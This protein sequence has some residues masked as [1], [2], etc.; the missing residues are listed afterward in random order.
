MASFDYG[1]SPQY[2]STIVADQSPVNGNFPNGVSAALRGLKPGTLYHFRA[3]G[4]NVAGVAKGAD[5]TFT[6][7]VNETAL[8]ALALGGATFTPA[9]NSATLS[10]TAVVPPSK[11]SI[12]VTP[13]AR[14]AKA[15][16]RVNGSVV[17]AGVASAPLT[18]VAGDNSIP[19]VVTAQD[20]VT[21]RTYT[22]HVIQATA[23]SATTAAATSL[24]ATGATLTGTA[25]SNA[26]ETAAAFEYGTSTMY[27]STAAATPAPVN[28]TSVPVRA[29]V[30]GLK[31]ATLYHFRTKATSAA[32]VAHGSDLTFT[33]QSDVATLSALAVSGGTLSPSF[34]SVV[35]AYTVHV[36]AATAA[37][38][39]QPA[40]SSATA[41]V[42]VNGSAVA[43]GASSPAITLVPGPN[44]IPIVVTAEDGK[45]LTYGLTVV[46]AEA[47]TVVTGVVTNPA[48]TGAMLHGSVNA[49]G[50]DTTVTFNY[51]TSASYGSTAAVSAPVTGA[52]ATPVVATLTKL[53]PGT[54]YHYQIKGVNAGGPSTGADAMFTTPSNVATLSGLVLSSGSLSPA[55]TGA[56]L[57]Y[58]A[59]VDNA[60]AT[61]TLTPTV[62]N[63]HA[64]VYVNGVQVV[65]GQASGALALSAG[66]N[67]LA[68]RVTAEDGTPMTY[69]VTVTR[70]GLAATITSVPATGIGSSTASV[71]G[72]AVA[73][74]TSTAL[75]FEYGTTM[76]Y[77][78]SFAAS[79][80]TANGTTSTSFNAVLTGLQPGT[81]Y[82]FRAKGVNITGSSHGEDLTFTTLNDTA[83]LT[84]L[85]P[86]TGTLSPA[87]NSGGT[88]YSLTVPNATS[89]ITFTPTVSAQSQATVR[90]NGQPVASGSPSAAL[91][92]AL[93]SNVITVAVTAEDGVS[94]VV[95]SVQVTRSTPPPVVVTL[96]ATV[97]GATSATLNAT[98]NA[99][100]A[101]AAVS[102]DYGLT[103]A[104]GSSI[105]AVPT[106]VTG[107]TV[108]PVSAQL[109]GL[110]P[111]MTYYCRVSAS[112]A[113]GVSSGL[114]VLFTTPNDVAT[115]SNLVLS[116]GALDQDFAPTSTA[117]SQT[118]PM[119][120]TTVTVTPTVT[121]GS[122]ATVQV[123]GVAVTSGQASGAL[124]LA[125]GANS[126]TLLVTAED[127]VTTT[128]Y[129]V[130][131]TVPALAGAAAQFA[132]AAFHP[133]PMATPIKAQLTGPTA[134]GGSLTGAAAQF[135]WNA[136]RGVS[137]YRLS[138]GSSVDGAELY[139]ASE[140]QTLARTVTLPTDGSEIYV[141]LSSM[142]DGAWQ[143]NRYVFTAA[144]TTPKAVLTA[145]AGQ[146]VLTTGSVV[147]TWDAL[148]GADRYAL[149]IGSTAATAE[150][151]DADEG[152]ALS[153]SVTLPTDGRELFVSLKTHLD[154]QWLISR[155]T[156]TAAGQGAPV[157][158]TITGP[159]TDQAL[160]GGTVTF[161]W[162]VG[163]G[164][165]EFLL[166]A[167]SRTGASDLYS[168][169][170]G[171]AQSA[172]IPLPVDGG[173]VY[174][175]LSS[176]I[177]G[178]WRTSEYL[179]EAALPP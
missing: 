157:A 122:H 126:I 40:T 73:H 93:G 34:S 151:Y 102:F 163:V 112:N 111:G 26:A 81:L 90:I 14:D 131:V 48:A 78:H 119:G 179:Y 159:A 74:N 21:S 15:T 37:V 115:L 82:H 139:D 100:G 127:G 178:E 68:V 61:V 67:V 55:F 24:T 98:V 140:G 97:A 135:T 91:P 28:G 9:F 118:A 110:L 86:G 121:A 95:Y 20:G 154:G 123:N 52:A 56:T 88:A 50:S 65:S 164:V 36:P 85:K 59:S 17:A 134:N 5:M 117:Y 51:G 109:T 104:Y 173:P 2:G 84:G 22:L 41:T 162:S 172:T 128:T 11:T 146:S 138:V 79:P 107:A 42:R 63:G 38:T 174:V 89:S 153:Q 64:T 129:T 106:P 13:T 125:V 114:N 31:P 169:S 152:A 70:P 144:D 10:Y 12:T 137:E 103:S 149:S 46:Q 18:L 49:N 77:G 147:F 177:N 145:P 136:G 35:N 160:P 71:G 171:L 45:K 165:S 176:L 60:T 113:G 170:Q 27:G 25:T 87:F 76:T 148:A 47:P 57:N 33:T 101:D 4:V 175:T 66:P 44:F 23:P 130:D 166:S 6:T 156:L 80:A 141:T 132:T 43:A 62:T 3:R 1:T 75:S 19:V 32:G 108:T 69:N 39:V 155:S 105:A 30:T 150:L 96:G 143:A 116:T 161:T 58:T 8:S 142:I 158:G 99:S 53:T 72:T 16:V 124:P 54:T 94:Q 29:V 7:P 120:A 133:A 92:L 167:G 168:A 83:A